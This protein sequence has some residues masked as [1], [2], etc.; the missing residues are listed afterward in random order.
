MN[1]NL[2]HIPERDQK[3]RNNGITMVMDTGLSLRQVED[4]I[5]AAGQNVE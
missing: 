1:A 4:H 2:P 5:H 3:K